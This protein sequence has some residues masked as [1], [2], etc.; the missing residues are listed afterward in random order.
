MSGWLRQTALWR[1]VRGVKRRLLPPHHDEPFPAESCA[2]EMQVIGPPAALEASQ[3]HTWTLHITN[4][5]ADAWATAGLEAVEISAR[6]LTLNGDVFGELL[7]YP[8]QNAIYPGEPTIQTVTIPTPAFVGDF[9][10]EIDLVQP[11]G[12]RFG[13]RTTQAK[14]A[15]VAVPVLGSRAMNIDYHQVYRTANLQENHWWVVGGYYSR[16]EYEK[17]SQGRLGMLIQHG[18]TPDSRVLDIG[19]GTGQMGDSLQGYLSEKG[20][21]YGTDI[22]AEAI[23]FCHE[24]F[25]KPNFVF[26]RGEM[27]RVPFDTTVGLFDLAIFFSV[28][29]HTFIDES[30]LLLAEAKRLLRPNGCVMVDIIVSPLVERSG[31]NR[32]EMIL[33]QEHF[34]RI[35]GA[36][37]FAPEIIGRWPWNPHAERLMLVLRRNQTS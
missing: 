11:G 15:L 17:S 7:E 3:T 10:L 18:L 34:F 19:C 8:L 9:T 35:V 29:T 32:G 16:D 22:G 14:P 33:N 24:R 31:G 13:E 27:T 12:G 4:Q 5:S 36:L 2:Y 28:F 21:Y 25:N 30:V 1:T 26:R 37:G 23:A 20:A 6:W